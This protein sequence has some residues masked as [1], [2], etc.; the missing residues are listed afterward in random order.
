[1]PFTLLQKISHFD[2]NHRL[3]ISSGVAVLTSCLIFFFA[4]A[5]FFT[6]M[7]LTLIWV[8]FALTVL[9]L[10]WTTIFVA[11][12][13]DL[14]LLSRMEDSGRT[15]IL[16]FVVVAAVASLFAVIDVLD[17]TNKLD[18]DRPRNTALAIF[19]VASS[20]SLVHTVFTLRYAHLYYGDDPNQ[21]KRPGGLDF[22]HDPEPD[23]L[24]FAYFSFVIGMT[25]QVSD[26]AVG[27]KPM[28]RTALGHGVLSFVFNAIIIALTISGVSG[29]I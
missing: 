15:L 27:S 5:P 10:A 11:H 3:I 13:R 24:D 29:L 2:S 17:S 16:L 26:V 19:A 1:M 9:L 28:R 8:A 18:P 20:W 22:P 23:Y 21:T 4:P 25:S 12:P 6:S 7:H 14:P